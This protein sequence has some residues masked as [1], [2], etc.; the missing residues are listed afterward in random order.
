[1]DLDDRLDVV[2]VRAHRL[3][4]HQVVFLG[5]VDFK[6]RKRWQYT[7]EAGLEFVR[8]IRY[9]A[10]CHGYRQ[11]RRLLGFLH[12]SREIGSDGIPRVDIVRC[13]CHAVA[14]RCSAA[15][16]DYNSRWPRQRSINGC[17]ELLDLVAA[18]PS[19][20]SENFSKV[21]LKL[22]TGIFMR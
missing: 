7:F 3:H 10:R 17:Q 18:V 12:G 2:L 8:R 20:V 16:D 1:M 21:D 14:E 22:S 4:E 5:D 6:T 15:P 19:Q 13:S 11:A 9:P